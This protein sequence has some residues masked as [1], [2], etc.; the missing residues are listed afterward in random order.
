[1]V[2]DAAAERAILAGICRFGSEG[3]NEVMDLV[4][5]STFY[6]DVNKTIFKCLKHLL[7]KDDYKAI[8]IPSIYSAAA[9]LGLDKVLQGQEEARHLKSI[10]V[11][12]VE[13]TNLG[14]FALRIRTLQVT[15]EIN[16]RCSLLDEKLKAV[17]GDEKIS[18]IISMVEDTVFNFTEIFG[19]DHDRPKLI[20]EG[21]MEYLEYLLENPCENIGIDTGFPLLNE[22]IGGGLRP[23]IAMIGARNKVGKTTLSC[24]IGRNI[25]K[26]GIP[27]LYIDTEMVEQG[28]YRDISNKLVAAD[29]RFN[30]GEL[31]KGNYADAASKKK[32]FESGQELTKIP[33]YHY[34]VAGKGFDKH[35][36]TIRRWLQTEVGF[37]DDGTANECVVIYDYIKVM[38]GDDLSD[39]IR[40]FQELGIRMTALQNL[41]IRRGVPMLGLSQLNRDGI[42]KENSGV[43]AGSDRIGWFCTS[44]SILKEKSAEE[45]EKDMTKGN[46]KIVTILSRYGPGHGFGEYVDCYMDGGT[47]FIEEVGKKTKQGIGDFQVEMDEHETVPFE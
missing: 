22:S 21:L 43:I 7:S 25:A 31:Q 20:G 2:R 17:T 3:Y 18:E 27:V 41:A 42:D 12:P 34:S 13:F 39:H 5:T 19:D 37:K 9:S 24:N 28:I 35:L 33:F 30:I 46:K 45:I 6:I 4:D 29:A 26:Q 10:T 1:M 11:F 14:K 38:G 47:A 16:E 23:G 15:R 44:F 40:E 36:S 8:D 32:V